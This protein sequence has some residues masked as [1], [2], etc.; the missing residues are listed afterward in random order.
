MVVHASNDAVVPIE[1]DD[2][3]VEEIRKIS[4]KVVYHR[5]E[6]YGHKMMPHFFKSVDWDEWMFQQSL[7]KR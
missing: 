1:Y 5:W 6:K 3:A 2:K 4:D 7:E